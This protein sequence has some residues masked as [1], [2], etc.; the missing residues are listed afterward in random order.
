MKSTLHPLFLDAGVR[1][2]VFDLDGTL[3]DSAA[4]ILHAM[5]L[6]FEQAGFGNLPADYMPDNLHGTN[7]GIMRSIVA[8]MGWTAPADFSSLRARY[9]TLYTAIDHQRTRLY[10]GVTDVLSAIR[11]AGLPMGICTNKL[12][13]GAL[14]ATRTVGIQG[15]FDFITGA[16][17]WPEAKPSPVPLLE[18]LRMLNLRPEEC[19]YFGDTSVD[20]Q[21]ARAAGVRFVL[22]ES[23]YGDEALRQAP[24][25]F[26]FH[27]WNELLA[28]NPDSALQEAGA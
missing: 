14:A 23:G 17:T 6:T 10:E 12:H 22:H 15:M 8:D 21:C 13:A 20:A 25:H 27:E 11:E 5:R 1:G 19:L 18:T 26:A 4:D 2:I 3:I 7:E 16:D 24:R 28:T 9:V